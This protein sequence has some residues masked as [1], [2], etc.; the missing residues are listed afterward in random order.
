V[1]NS[2]G[3]RDRKRLETRARVEKAA[4]EIVLRDGLQQATV[5]AISAAADIS[6][7]TFFNYFDS[8]EDAILGL[9]DLEIT[10]ELIDAHLA[11]ADTADIV[12]GLIGLVLEL[13]APALDDSA[14][15]LSRVEVIRR[16]PELLTR[17]ITQFTR[18]TDTLTSWARTLMA[19]DPRF[20]NLD[21]ATSPLA[22]PI[23]ALC[24]SAVRIV[25]K[26]RIASGT[27]AST[28]DIRTRAVALARETVETLR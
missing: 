8:K 17:Q 15:H 4:V 9:R 22:E 18:T 23:L 16:H 28:E 5:D 3:L 27:D 24:A 13:M 10:A 1:Q 7:R 6:P 11:E 14:L 26:E 12:D 21:P 19:R 20:S 2:V 25:V